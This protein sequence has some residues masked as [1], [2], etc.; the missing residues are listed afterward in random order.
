MPLE[1]A[2]PARDEPILCEPLRELFTL[3]AK[4]QRD[5]KTYPRNNPILVR[6]RE[7]LHAKILPILAVEA[8]LVIDV[9][10]EELR[11][12]GVDVYR[13]TDPRES[14]SFHLY[15]HGL[16]ELTFHAGL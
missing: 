7:E 1:T 12:R 8:D 10:S 9:R 5:F 13:N 14:L 15:R 11:Y 16:R 2:P 3:L 4:A 6:R